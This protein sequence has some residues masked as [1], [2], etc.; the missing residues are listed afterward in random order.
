M[1]AENETQGWI[2]SSLKFFELKFQSLNE[3]LSFN[4]ISNIIVVPVRISEL[5]FHFFAKSMNKGPIVWFDS[6]PPITILYR[7]E[8]VGQ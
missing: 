5:G 4:F 8:F 1:F 7:N 6:S 3:R 2:S